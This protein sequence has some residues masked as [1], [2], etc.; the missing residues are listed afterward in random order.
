MNRICSTDT[1]AIVG[2]IFHSRYC[3]IAIGQVWVRPGRDQEQAHF[4]I[5]ERGDEAEQGG[6]DNARQ[7]GGAGG[8]CAGTWSGGRRRGF[9][10]ELPS[11]AR[12]HAGGGWR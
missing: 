11:T 10:G 3:R 2:S 5:A 4:Q 9:G 6:G 1:A 8:E 7:N 12:I